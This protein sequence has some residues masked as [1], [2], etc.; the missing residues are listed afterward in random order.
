MIVVWTAVKRATTRGAGWR[1]SGRD[2]EQWEAV[3][4]F[5]QW[6]FPL[7]EASGF[8]FYAPMLTDED[9]ATFRGEER[10]R[11]NVRRSFRRFLA[12]VGLVLTEDGQVVEGPNFAS[13]A[14]DFWGRPNHNWL[15]TTR[16]LR[17]LRLLGLEWE[18]R[19]FYA[20]LEALTTAGT[21]P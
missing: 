20:K 6:L 19:A 12:F 15:R 1:T 4:D 18:A 8:N 3:H 14:P 13:R 17:S 2:D 9:I 7:P 5:I 11:G 21:S 16:V 10:L